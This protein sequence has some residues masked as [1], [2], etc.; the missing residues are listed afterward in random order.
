MKLPLKAL[1]FLRSCLA[2]PGWNKGDSSDLKH[3][4]FYISGKLLVETLPEV[5]EVPVFTGENTPTNQRAYVKQLT[6]FY[7]ALSPDFTLSE[8]EFETCAACLHWFINEDRMPKGAPA[9]ALYD[10]F[11][12]APAP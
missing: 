12:L 2:E 6:V 10:A 11:K 7:A 1:E 3:Q 8:K 4:R 5:P 9:L